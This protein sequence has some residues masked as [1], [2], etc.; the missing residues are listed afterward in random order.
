VSRRKRLTNKQKD[1]LWHEYGGKCWR[2]GLPINKH[3]RELHWGHIV[4]R[5]CGGSDEPKNMAPEH[6]HCNQ[7]DNRTHATPMAA[8]AK[9]ISQ[10]HLGIDREPKMKL[11]KRF[12]GTVTKWNPA[13]RKYEPLPQ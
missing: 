5:S 4:A 11:S 10:R 6:S 9:R 8:K 2:C 13:T 1:D 12:D 7:E 3:K